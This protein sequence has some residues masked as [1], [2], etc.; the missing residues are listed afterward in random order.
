MAEVK[1]LGDSWQ[2]FVVIEFILGMFLANRSGFVHI[3]HIRIY[4]YTHY[5]NIFYCNYVKQL[6]LI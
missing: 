1:E 3:L 6:H 4:N 2:R 5:I